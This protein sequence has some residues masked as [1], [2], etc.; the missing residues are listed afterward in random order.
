LAFFDF[1]FDIARRDDEIGGGD[2]AEQRVGRVTD[3]RSPNGSTFTP[4]CS[5]ATA[6]YLL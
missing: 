5:A 3:F 6:G 1:G 4:W 2:M